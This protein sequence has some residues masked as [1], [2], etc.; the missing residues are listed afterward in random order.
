MKLTDTANSINTIS[1]NPRPQ[2]PI[3]AILPINMQLS[4]DRNTLKGL[5]KEILLEIEEEKNP[6]PQKSTAELLDTGSM[7][8][9]IISKADKVKPAT[10]SVASYNPENSTY[11][12]QAN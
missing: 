10:C 6:K 1:I 9:T 8:K 3:S 4:L 2:A 12:N 11:T 5:V 7:S